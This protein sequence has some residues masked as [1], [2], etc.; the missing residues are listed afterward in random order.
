MSLPTHSLN[1]IHE[2]QLLTLGAQL[3]GSRNTLIGQ[4]AMAKVVSLI[5]VIVGDYVNDTESNPITFTN[6]SGRTIEIVFYADPDVSIVEK[7]A[8]GDRPVVSIEVKGGRDK[9]NIH[10]R[11]GEAEKSHQKAKARGFYELW[12]I[13]GVDIEISVAQSESPTTTQFFFLDEIIDT[14]SQAGMRFK[15]LFCSLVNIRSGDNGK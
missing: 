7:M 5:Q 1:L 11:L 6:D 4:K 2:L 8:S 13:L 3:R 12:T 15:D 14:N 10:N 9:S